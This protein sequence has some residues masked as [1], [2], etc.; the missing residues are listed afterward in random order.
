MVSNIFFRLAIN[1][2]TSLP[3]QLDWLARIDS[4]QIGPGLIWRGLNWVKRGQY[5][6]DHARNN[7]TERINRFYE[8]NN[9]PMSLSLSLS[10]ILLCNSLALNGIK[11]IFG[12]EVPWD[13]TR[14]PHT[15]LPWKFSCQ[16]NQSETWQHATP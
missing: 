7:R 12:M 16:D 3:A 11:S 14:Q 5:K 1:N 8:S 13:N 4:R 2:D 6:L 15:L 10:Y 9:E